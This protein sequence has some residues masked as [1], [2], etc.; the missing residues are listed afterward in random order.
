MFKKLL[1]ILP[2]TLL[3]TT[4]FADPIYFTANAQQ[5]APAA[6]AHATPRAA[7]YPAELGQPIYFTANKI[8]TATPV[9]AI[10]KAVDYP[11]YVGQPIYF[12]AN[13]LR[14]GTKVATTAAAVRE[15][16]SAN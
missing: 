11:T 4:A 14:E 8:R 10:G 5:A 6:T 1:A 15:R 7:A 3:A 2:A 9:A 16:T 13:K 12:I